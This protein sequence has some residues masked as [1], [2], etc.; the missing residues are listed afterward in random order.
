MKTIYTLMFFTCLLCCAACD[1]EDYPLYDVNQKDMIFIE[2]RNSANELTDTLDYEFGFD[3]ARDHVVKIPVKVMGL[4]ADKE[5][6][7]EVIPV[8]G[9]TDMVEGV[10]YTIE[11]TVIKANMVDGEIVV[12]LLRDHDVAIQTKQF[13]LNL[14]L[15]ENDM[16]YPQ[17]QSNF[18]L[19]Y[20]DIPIPCPLIHT[21]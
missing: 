16:F 6:T 21:R 5:R 3:I 7:F 17:G 12:H 15:K 13:T 9:T 19:R 11:P 20:S 18:R 4:P 2:Y 1:K 10:H 8:S 14:Q